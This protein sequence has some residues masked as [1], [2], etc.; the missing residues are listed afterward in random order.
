MK[1]KFVCNLSTV[2]IAKT[3]G[4]N[5]GQKIHAWELPLLSSVSASWVFLPVITQKLTLYNLPNISASVMTSRGVGLDINLKTC[6]GLPL[7]SLL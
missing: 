2:T 6:T 3:R 5:S 4:T 1:I 7:W